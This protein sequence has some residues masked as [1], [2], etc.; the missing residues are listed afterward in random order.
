MTTLPGSGRRLWRP[1]GSD[2]VSRAGRHRGRPLPANALLVLVGWAGLSAGG[3][4]EEDLQRWRWPAHEPEQPAAVA[5]TAEAPATAPG[6]ASVFPTP[7]G[8]NDRP[9]VIQSIDFQILRVRAV[10]GAFS[11]SGKIWN[12]LDEEAFPATTRALLRKNG[13]RLGVGKVASWPQI[14]AILDAEEVELSSDQ[15]AVRNG[16]PLT[17]EIDPQMRDQT[18]FLFR[19]D[20]TMA[21]RTYAS[22]RMV[23]RIEYF[24]SLADA[25]AVVID[26]MPEVVLPFVR[27]RPAL[28]TGG[29]V[30]E[31][32]H[33]P[34][35]PLRE[36]AARA[37]IAPESFLAI[38]PSGAA[39]QGHLAGS[40]LLCEEIDG[41]VFESM[42][43]ITPQI[44][45][46]VPVVR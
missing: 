32:L 27:P 31:E 10:R 36:L 8:M 28:G 38:G 29:W 20:G 15:Q 21:G 19:A 3:C 18:L 40:L 6:A 25:D 2:G 11:E 33:Q 46:R 16:L 9:L 45:S 14:K 35:R 34:T 30:Q 7:A 12:P 41:Q 5:G 22:S 13:L 39:Q 4:T 42:Y 43:F 1:L 26:V 24:I 37:Q 23:L 44:R 17:V